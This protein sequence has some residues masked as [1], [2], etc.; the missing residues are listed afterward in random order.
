MNS[1]SNY[2]IYFIG[3]FSSHLC[4]LIS[5]EDSMKGEVEPSLLHGFNVR[6][7]YIALTSTKHRKHTATMRQDA[8]GQCSQNVKDLYQLH[9]MEKKQ[10][11]IDVSLL[12]VD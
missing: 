1:G 8:S 3:S 9:R 12:I 2:Y 10:Q 7:L 5:I 6:P 11:P 4:V